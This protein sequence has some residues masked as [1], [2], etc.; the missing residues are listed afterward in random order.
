[1]IFAI[2]AQII[3]INILNVKSISKSFD[4]KR[5]I[6]SNHNCSYNFFT[7]LGINQADGCIDLSV[8][9]GVDTYNILIQFFAYFFAIGSLLSLIFSYKKLSKERLN[10]AIQNSLNQEDEVELE[11]QNK[12]GCIKVLERI[13][14]Y[15]FSPNFILHICRISAILW[16]YSYQNFYS[17]GI[18]IWLFF[19]FLL[20]T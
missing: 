11:E 3:L 13:K 4:Y 5:I 7:Q 18:I 6:I 12:N 9:D 10:K 20:Y 19:S 14:D 2:T 17:I 1:M 16:L 15:F 8:K